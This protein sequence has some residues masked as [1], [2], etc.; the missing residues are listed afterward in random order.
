MKKIDDV[1][2]KGSEQDIEVV[3]LGSCNCDCPVYNQ[4]VD[5]GAY[6]AQ[7]ESAGI[8]SNCGETITGYNSK[9]TTWW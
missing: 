5:N 8:G 1:F 2:S 9:T 3:A 7:Y 6:E 4:D